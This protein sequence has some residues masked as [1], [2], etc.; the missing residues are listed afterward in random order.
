MSLQD[1]HLKIEWI[2]GTQNSTADSLSRKACNNSCRQCRAKPLYRSQTVNKAGAKR[3][4]DVGFSID[5]ENRCS[6]RTSA[7]MTSYVTAVD[8]Q[9]E[10]G[11][12]SETE[13][14]P[15]IAWLYTFGTAS[16]VSTAR[17]TNG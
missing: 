15:L 13:T 5:D 2:C 1:Y 4:Y 8:A 6:E 12:Y 3:S 14:E 11:R 17:G 7:R 10:T 9:I 16:I